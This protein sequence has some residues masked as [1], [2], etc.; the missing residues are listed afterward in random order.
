MPTFEVLAVRGTR[1]S[2]SEGDIVAIRPQGHVWGAEELSTKFRIYEADFSLG[3]TVESATA[4]FASPSY[5]PYD[6][7][8]PFPEPTH[9]ET[10]FIDGL[11]DVVSRFTGERIVAL[12]RI[13]DASLRSP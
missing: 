1:G 11:G 10:G 2:A 4:R 8:G 13:I 7:I 5:P 3:E 9:I 12:A 6:D